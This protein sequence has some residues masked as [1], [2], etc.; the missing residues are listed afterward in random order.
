M[1]IGCNHFHTHRQLDHLCVYDWQL[2]DSIPDLSCELWCRQGI[3]HP[4]FQEVPYVASEQAHNSG[5]LALHLAS[6][7]GLR[8][9]YVLGCDWG[10]T[11]RSIFSYGARD[12]ELKYTND[13]RKVMMRIAQKISIVVVNDQAPDVGVP[14]VSRDEFLG[15]HDW[16][17]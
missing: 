12:S 5:V 15:S 13:Q 6:Y 1:E 8:R 4:R 11:H 17:R 9:V 7:L 10:L 16:T 3:K 2:F 14:V